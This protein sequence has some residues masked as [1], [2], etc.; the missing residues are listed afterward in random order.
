MVCMPTAEVF[1]FK[2]E[3]LFWKFVVFFND[4]LIN[5]YGQQSFYFTSFRKSE[6][7][8]SNFFVID[9]TTYKSKGLVSL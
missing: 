6:Q 8:I 3:F 1:F 5:V 4:F 9:Q 2:I 7:N